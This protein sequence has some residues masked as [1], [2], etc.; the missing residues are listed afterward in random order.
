METPDY[1][2]KHFTKVVETLKDLPV[3]PKVPDILQSVKNKNVTIITAETGSGKTL[4]ANAALADESDHPVWVLVPRRFLA[5]N[6]AETIAKISGKELG[7]EV[8]YAIG[9][10][11]T[12]RSNFDKNKSKLIFATYGYALSSGLLDD[13][14]TKTIVC[15]E[16]HEKGIDI[17]LARAI[18]H[19]RLK[20]EKESGKPE[21]QRLN[22]V[23]M[24]ATINAENQ[25]NYW[26]DIAQTK[27]IEAP[28]KSCDC[29]YSHIT[30]EQ[31]PFLETI[32]DVLLE[33]D[34]TEY[35]KAPP[36]HQQKGVA[37]F[38][39]GVGKA[40]VV[41][42]QLRKLF[43]ESH[44]NNVEVA[45]I[46]SDM[47][48]IQRKEAL[49]APKDGKLKVLV[50]T[51]VIESG[52]NI[53]W[54]RAG[55]SNG[56]SKIPSYNY[57]DGSEALD[58]EELPE[59]RITQQ[60]GRVKRL[61]DGIFILHSNVAK[62]DRPKE[63]TPDISRISLSNLAMYA[64]NYNIDPT[65]LKFDATVSARAKTDSD[66]QADP[67]LSPEEEAFNQQEKIKYKLKESKKLLM[68][69]NL[70]KDDWSLTQQGQFVMTMPLGA[71]AG[72]IMVAAKERFPTYIDDA[73][74]LSAVVE[75]MS[76][77]GNIT[78][79]IKPD[80][81][82]DE[83]AEEEEHPK[84]RRKPKGSKG[85]DT[86]AKKDGGLRADMR[87]GHGED[88]NSDV[89]DALKAY[90]KTGAKYDKDMDEWCRIQGID[91]TKY[92]EL[93]K[94]GYEPSEEDCQF[95]GGMT[96]KTF[97]ET[98]EMERTILDKHCAERNLSLMRFKEIRGIVAD[99]HRRLEKEGAVGKQVSD[100]AA[101]DLLI[102]M[103][104]HGSVSR[105]F[106]QFV[107]GDSKRYFD[108][109]RNK[110]RYKEGKFTT[111]AGTDEKY[112]VAS[113]RD[114]TT[115]NSDESMVVATNLTRVTPEALL[116][117]LA[118]RPEL[119]QGAKISS[120]GD[121]QKLEGNYLGGGE[122]SLRIP[123]RPSRAVDAYLSAVGAKS[124]K[125][126]SKP[127]GVANSAVVDDTPDLG[128]SPIE[129]IPDRELTNYAKVV[130]AI[131]RAMNEWFETYRVEPEQYAELAKLGREPSAEEYRDLGGGMLPMD[132][133]FLKEMEVKVIASS[134]ADRN[135]S[136]RRFNE[137]AADL[138]T[139]TDGPDADDMMEGKK[140]ARGRR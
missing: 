140:P 93:A 43:E 121:K 87:I 10:K 115:L 28:G 128:R 92:D 109:M 62:E 52:M 85:T 116:E 2:Q 139:N 39:E 125:T 134:C 96:L 8:G 4:L 26:N 100:P 61:D 132:F 37:V 69:L 99:M 88:N 70:M 18:I 120:N 103:M 30:P 22:L 5:I 65:T 79:Q 119:L 112:A 89:L 77:K 31:K 138:A 66:P 1:T 94:Q 118:S 74:E 15:D 111:T 81:T 20:A 45:T 117:F 104:M 133:K 7:K 50:G 29:K 130:R 14:K 80:K 113:L 107:D 95:K 73:V 35:K 32:R 51:N 38:V 55:V 76:H 12:G 86:D 42:K 23:E 101:D 16:V 6:A 135:M 126:K 40:E 11:S 24:S 64:A 48:D 110:G 54:L 34:A 44:I 27:L 114:Y 13:P 90:R 17:S 19:R 56:L 3:A 71:E 33:V 49:A 136:V 41:A 84:P 9:Q 129:A 127:A 91:R 97:T 21:S 47:D 63:N 25:A 137:I 60:E 122:V 36:E 59:W 108:L 67:E 102:Q 57:H 78:P 98:Q 82:L 123:K 72:A 106:R 46:Y 53:P 124:K 83:M 105:I 131:E 58:T 68:Q 75:V